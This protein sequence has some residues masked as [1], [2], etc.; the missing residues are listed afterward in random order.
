MSYWTKRKISAAI[1]ALIGI[2]CGILAIWVASGSEENKTFGF[3]VGIL[4]IC[5]GAFFVYDFFVGA[6]KDYNRDA[7][8]ARKIEAEQEQ[9]RERIKEKKEMEN[10]AKS[11]DASEV[12]EESLRMLKELYDNGVLSE[13]EFTEKKKQLLKL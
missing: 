9:L 2:P 10:K 13:E 6:N 4:A 3:I 1:K 11:I 5:Y 8:Y 7:E 12:P